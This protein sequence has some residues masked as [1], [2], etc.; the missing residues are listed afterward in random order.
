[1]Q[2]PLAYLNGELVPGDQAV[3]PVSDAGIVQG[4][5]VSE[6][7]RTF[8]HQLF[9]LDEHLHRFTDSLAVVG[10]ELGLDF[11]GLA[12]VCQDLV[13]H[14]S[15]AIDTENDLGMVLFATAGPYATYSGDVADTA[16]PRSTLCAHT[17]PLPFE[18]W[19]QVQAAPSIKHRSRLHYYLADREAKRIASGARAVLLDDQGRL[20]ETTAASLLL[21][22]GNRILSPPATSVLPSISVAVIAELAGQLDL[23]FIE[24]DLR[25]EDVGQADE[26][27]VASTPYCLAPVTR[28]NDQPVGSGR[29]GPISDR[30]LGA[31]DQL[32]GL[33]IRK[34]IRQGAESRRGALVPLGEHGEQ[35]A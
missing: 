5:T 17:F 14:N 2:Q 13:A 22:R 3:L 24:Q 30:L 18:L 32:V 6:T 29:P 20:T 31:W 7:L 9:R 35:Q 16:E 1:M 23:E 33:D 4:A 10:F 25:P 34:Q 15:I 8:G 12:G 11:A 27:L 19:D 26:A 28:F 21:I